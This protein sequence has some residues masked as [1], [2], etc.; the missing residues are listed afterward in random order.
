MSINEYITVTNTVINSELKKVLDSEFKRFNSLFNIDPVNNL[1][2]KISESV[3]G[4]KRLRANLI[5]YGYKIFVKNTD[6]N[7]LEEIL[8]LSAFIELIHNYFLIIDDVIDRSAERR[9]KKTIHH[10]YKD[11][12]SHLDDD[13]GRHY[14]NS[15][16]VLA[17]MVSGQLG[18]QLLNSIDIDKDV[19][20]RII[21]KTFNSINDTCYGEFL[22]VDV[23]Y[24]KSTDYNQI[25]NVYLLKT[26]KY[27]YELPLHIG[28]I[29]AKCSQ[30]VLD[31][32]TKYSIS[33]GIAFQLQDD[34]LGLYGD[35][36]LT[37][38]SNLS[39]VVEGKRTILI[40]NAMNCASKDGKNK[41][42][43]YLGKKDLNEE[44]LHIVREIVK[45]SGSL[46]YSQKLI[47]EHSDKALEI[48]KEIAALNK[49]D[50]KEFLKL[51]VEYNIKRD[52]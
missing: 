10:L 45:E 14:G 43:S 25:L 23:Q 8:K 28:A 2:S 34:I 29:C 7:K 13:E 27:T 1:I 24:G 51:L 19:R 49:C 9:N 41:L 36:K 6:R 21:D 50:D 44:E 18:F 30:N 12:Y 37:G 20:S 16:A 17:G 5:Y 39:D 52:K 15:V 35:E 40:V 38:K 3:K 11:T 31:L 22:D 48:Y 26:A 4:G 47:K 32:L 46:D 33:A 42:K